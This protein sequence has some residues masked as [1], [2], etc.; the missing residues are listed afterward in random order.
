MI[1][2]PL[3]TLY[4]R[5]VTRALAAVLIEVRTQRVRTVLT[6]LAVAVGVASLV[7]LVSAG[8]I[9]KASVER[10]VERLAGRPGTA[11]LTVVTGNAALG[12]SFSGDDIA[13]LSAAAERQAT[14][15]AT[16]VVDI[17]SV[18]MSQASNFADVGVLGIGP[19]VQQIRRLDVRAG[20]FLS[21]DDIAAA[22]R[23]IV[24]NSGAVD[25]LGIRP[26]AIGRP[27]Q[28]SGGISG[29]FVV[30]GELAGSRSEQ[31]TGMF[32]WTVSSVDIDKGAVTTGFAFRAHHPEDVGPIGAS[33]AQVFEGRAE[34]RRLEVRTAKDADE[35]VGD[36]ISN[37]QL[38]LAFVAGVSVVVGA[39]GVAN[40]LLSAV[41]ERK[42]EIGVRRSFGAT[43][44]DI[45]RLV[46]LEA[47][48]IATGGA[49]AGVWFAVVLVAAVT[50]GF[51]ASEGFA[52]AR[53]A[54]PVW[55][56]MV[57]VGAALAVG[58]LAGL[59][60]AVRAGRIGVI[61]ALRGD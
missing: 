56:V 52:V 46:L 39:I 29:Q 24:L 38:F 11:T 57:A 9:A 2:E 8:E 43:S 13:A 20:R 19:E 33:L 40:V 35:Q 28:L 60:P 22:R 58:A 54:I 26:Y 36:I 3:P 17:P 15:A 14:I 1:G 44:G 25:R 45:R 31:P 16:P 23:V 41:G 48:L 5:P 50:A 6:S 47:L 42:R 37:M 27:I 4:A 34:G 18:R 7:A 51:N 59:R 55:A 12:G 32:P 49:F 21:E 10:R 53:F 61:D 30:V